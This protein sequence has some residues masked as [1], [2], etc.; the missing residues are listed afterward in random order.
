MPSYYTWPEDG[1][2]LVVCTAENH[3][4][5]AFLL[6][7]DTAEHAAAMGRYR[8]QTLTGAEPAGITV[9]VTAAA[10]L[11]EIMFENAS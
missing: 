9:R 3:W 8:Y 10:D 11:P 7:A 4:P 1:H 6:T 2:Y 5:H